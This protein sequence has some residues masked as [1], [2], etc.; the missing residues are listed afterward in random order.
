MSKVDSKS[1]AVT[2]VALTKATGGTN[3]ILVPRYDDVEDAVID[4]NACYERIRP[5][6]L[7]FDRSSY[8][9][10]REGCRSVYKTKAVVTAL[11]MS[12]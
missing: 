4:S 9:C 7:K 11:T 5:C 8:V 2:G 12:L 6:C 10:Y 1:A 3:A